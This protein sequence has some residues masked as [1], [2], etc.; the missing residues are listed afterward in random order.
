LAGPTEEDPWC[1][2][3]CDHV[4]NPDFDQPTCQRYE[5]QF[6][7]EE[8][9]AVEK[10]VFIKP[11]MEEV[12]A[13][14]TLVERRLSIQEKLGDQEGCVAW[15]QRLLPLREGE[16][17]VYYVNRELWQIVTDINLCR[18]PR[19]FEEDLSLFPVE[20]N[21]E[22]MAFVPA[23]P[24]MMGCN[25]AAAEKDRKREYPYHPVELPA[26]FVDRHET[27]L[28]SYRRCVQAGVCAEPKEKST[29]LRFFNWGYA[30]R[31]SHPINGVDWAQSN[32]YC[33]WSGK[34]LCSEAEWEK[35]ARGT[36]GRT[37]PWGTVEPNGRLVL[38]DTGLD[39]EDVASKPW[40]VL[41]LTEPVC[42]HSEGNSPYGLCDMAGNVW[43]WVAD[44]YA[45]DYY[46]V[47]P[48]KNPRGPA[49]GTAKVIRSGRFHRVGFH[50][51][52]C[53]RSFF[54]PGDAYAY[55]GF[56]CCRSLD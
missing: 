8:G 18:F 53:R 43:E 27:T 16:P 19:S 17:P 55:L 34:R 42:S 15:C 46:Q 26:F 9:R 35:A 11:C 10:Q 20:I 54:P 23:G 39:E 14:G 48:Q 21:C 13:W 32:A 33:E 12:A 28:A 44:W 50:L 52:A 4:F 24:F 41:T 45:E 7:I 29:S 25:P 37:Y 40:P 31:E 3:Q 30:H 47:S 22:G 56:R 5:T 2:E 38:I 36:D 49:E 51:A 6:V 1:L